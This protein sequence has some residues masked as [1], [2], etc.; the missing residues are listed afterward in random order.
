MESFDLNL[1]PKLIPPEA[2]LGNY[3]GN[4]KWWRGWFTP[5]SLISDRSGPGSPR[6]TPDIPKY[7]YDPLMSLYI[8]ENCKVIKRFFE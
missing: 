3:T 4:P 6:T 7:T 5:S 2:A 8:K 1:L